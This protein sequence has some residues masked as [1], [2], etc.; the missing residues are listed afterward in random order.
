MYITFNPHTKPIALNNKMNNSIIESIR[1]DTEALKRVEAFAN[2]YDKLC[3]EI[4]SSRLPEEEKQF[5]LLAATRHIVFNYAKIADY[6]AHS[7]EDLQKLM[8]KSALVL[9]DVDDAIANGYVR[10]SENIMK[11][12]QETGRPTNT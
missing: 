11:I 9:I 4:K 5:L 6:Y 2:K 12:M 8:E 7:G 3:M 10:V 1:N